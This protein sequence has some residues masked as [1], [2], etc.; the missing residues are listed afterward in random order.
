MP[1]ATTLVALA[2][3][4]ALMPAM[5][6]LLIDVQAFDSRTH[7]P[8]NTR[9]NVELSCAAAHPPGDTAPETTQKQEDRYNPPRQRR[10][11]Q[12]LLYRLFGYL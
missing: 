4:K 12:R 7:T 2:F 11:L 6:N 8:I 10:Q 3:F 9:P 5:C 1:E